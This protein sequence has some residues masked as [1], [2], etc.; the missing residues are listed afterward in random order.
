MP[1]KGTRNFLPELCERSSLRK[2][3]GHTTNHLPEPSN[4]VL[5][6]LLD[7]CFLP[8][9]EGIEA[10]VGAESTEGKEVFSLIPLVSSVFTVPLRV[11]EAFGNESQDH[12]SVSSFSP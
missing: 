2:A 3:C 6:F 1:K 7:S 8:S 10:G 9:P 11:E 12:S 4:Y 5:F